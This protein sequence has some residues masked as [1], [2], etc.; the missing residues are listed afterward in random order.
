MVELLAFL[1]KA[2]IISIPAVISPGAMTAGTLAAAP[3][4]RHAG[5]LVAIGH[6]IVELPLMVIIVVGLKYGIDIEDIRVP[7]GFAGGAMLLAM[8]GLLVTGADKP[9][10]PDAAPG[11]HG[12][13]V[14]GVVL[15]AG[16][17]LFLAWWASAGLALATEA[18]S[19]GVAAFVLFALT[20]WVLDVI[21][22]EA[23][24]LAA[25]KGT[26][27][28]GDRSRRVIVRICAVVLVYFGIR[29]IYGAALALLG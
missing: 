17:P 20:H 25:A 24:T 6:G 29:F 21:W 19:L 18:V 7:V 5:A 15:S 14:T 26:K 1:G 10:D 28:L 3:R 16:N 9:V 2:I 13:L 8:A 23:L 4:N 22:L 11:K 12:P 27:L